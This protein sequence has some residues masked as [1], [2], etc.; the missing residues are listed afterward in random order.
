M[1]IIDVEQNTPE[2]LAERRGRVMGS[3]AQDVIPKP[4][5]KADVV[6]TLKDLGL[7]YIQLPG[8]EPPTT[9]M[10]TKMLSLDDL[11]RLGRKEDRKIGFYQLIADVLAIPPAEEETE[12]EY[13][14]ASDRGHGLEQAAIDALSEH[15]GKKIHRVGI[16]TRDDEPRIANS[17][18]GMIKNSRGKWTG[19]AEVKCLKSALHIKAVIEDKIPDASP[20][21]Y[22]SQAMQYFV[23]NDDLEV[24]Y[25]VFY[26]PR[27]TPKPLHI[28]EVHREDVEDKVAELLA[29]QR[30]TLAE[31]D[32]IIEGLAF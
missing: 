30:D 29:Y 2:W 10:L 6:K 22:W 1:Q 18:D 19:A 8:G 14:S 27:F 12:E 11:V 17:P 21:N 9:K 31:V 3:I 20:Y 5:L 23:V 15:I 7:E 13:G 25:F 4:P 26:D 24:L 28:I 16:C 32:R